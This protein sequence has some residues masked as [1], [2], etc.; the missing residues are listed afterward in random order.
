M[1]KKSLLLLAAVAVVAPAFAQ[2]GTTKPKPS[3]S[4]SNGTLYHQGS[5]QVW[6]NCAK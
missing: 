4:S 6:A 1:F 2:A 5:G 3:F